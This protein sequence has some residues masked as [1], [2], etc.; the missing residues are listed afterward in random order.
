M[1]PSP[2]GRSRDGP[3]HWKTCGTKAVSDGSIVV[4]R[5]VSGV[6]GIVRRA[7]D[8]AGL[9]LN[10][11]VESQTFLPNVQF[12]VAGQCCAVLDPL[13]VVHVWETGAYF[14]TLSIRLLD[15]PLRYC[16]AIVSPA[17]R[18]TSVIA[19][20]GRNAWTQEVHRFL[21]SAGAHP[22]LQLQEQDAKTSSQARSA[23]SPPVCT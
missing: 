13:T 6:R 21:E 18:P 3:F 14:E 9:K 2:A 15:Q 11:M 16:Y 20:E 4:G 19:T 12:I 17:H 7:F 23:A 1:W 10:P 22:E 5:D 8:E